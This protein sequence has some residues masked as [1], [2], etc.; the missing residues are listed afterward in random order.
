MY[1][2]DIVRRVLLKMAEEGELFC[3][4]IPPKLRVPFILR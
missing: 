3:D 2:G 4:T 1:L